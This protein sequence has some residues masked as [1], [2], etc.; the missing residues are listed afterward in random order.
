MFSRIRHLFWQMVSYFRA[1]GSEGAPAP[2]QEEQHGVS[3]QP[4]QPAPKVQPYEK[5]P[6]RESEPQ[7][8]HTAIADQVTVAA[9][10]VAQSSGAPAGERAAPEG[11]AA[12]AQPVASDQGDGKEAPEENRHQRRRRAALRRAGDAEYRRLER[13]RLKHDQWVTPQGPHPV[14]RLSAAPQPDT[15]AR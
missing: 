7:A 9:T 5:T 8:H 13:A 1:G 2:R 6:E 10:T 3:K 4:Y 15:R 11:A 14:E 12:V